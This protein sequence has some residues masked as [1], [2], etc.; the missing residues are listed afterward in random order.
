[1]AIDW[2]A[3]NFFLV[4]RHLLILPKRLWEVQVIQSLFRA[5]IGSAGDYPQLEYR[6][7][8]VSTDA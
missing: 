8:D 7:C 3:M 2:E 6:Q 1:M 5:E 4:S